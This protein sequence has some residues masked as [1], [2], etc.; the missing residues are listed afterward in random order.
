MLPIEPSIKS[1]KHTNIIALS[2]KVWDGWEEQYRQFTRDK[3]SM[4]YRCAS[5]K[6]VRTSGHIFLIG[7][8][9]IDNLVWP[10]GKKASQEKIVS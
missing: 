4:T 1:I 8:M 7:E 6:E 10:Y 5:I 2:E 9:Y 3:L